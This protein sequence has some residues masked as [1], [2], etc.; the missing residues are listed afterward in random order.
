MTAAILQARDAR[1]TFGAVAALDGVTLTLHAGDR[2]AVVGANG[3]GKT[4]L[5]HLL[6][7]T[8]R[9]SAGRIEWHG[10]D[11]TRQGPVRRARAGIGRS[12]Q[13]PTVL[14][15]LSTVDNLILGAWPRADGARYGPLHARALQ[16]AQ[17]L[18]LADRADTPAGLLSHGQRR[19]LDIGIALAGSPEVLLLDE[20]A[21]GLN[22]SADLDRLLDLLAALPTAMAVL[23]VE[24]HLDVVE[25]IADTVT[26][27][28]R[29]RVVRTRDVARAV[30]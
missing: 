26:V 15:S 24:H 11:V 5:L 9:P 12:F 21:A 17:S 7:G 14:P 22:G 2:H 3:A 23:L 19:L 16:Q 13:M 27:L 30:R 1:K 20:P 8:L 4:T 10:R 29:G 18:G 28:E 6:A 25:A